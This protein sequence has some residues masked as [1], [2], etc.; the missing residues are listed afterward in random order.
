MM[1]WTRERLGD[2]LLKSGLVSEEQLEHALAVQAKQGGRLGRILANQSVITEEQL[3]QMIAEQ[4]HLELIDLA[5]YEVDGSVAR[6]VTAQAA[7]RHQ[8]LP[9]RVENDR[10]VVAMANP[11]DIEAIDT[12]RVMTGYDVQ[13]VV[14]TEGDISRGIRRYLESEQSVIMAAAQAT[15]AQVKAGPVEEAIEMENV[16]VVNL[17]NKLIDDAIEERAS[18]V[19]FEPQSDHVRV[20]YRIDGVLHDAARVPKTVEPSLIS[21]LKIMAEA[22]IS[23]KRVPQDGHFYFRHNGREVDVRAAVLPT[24]NGENVSLRLLSRG[25]S[26]MSLTQVGFEENVLHRFGDL[27]RKP[28]GAILVTGPTGSGKTTTMYAAI[29][30]LNDSEKKI[31]TIEDPV[32]YHIPGVMQTQVNIKTGLTFAVGLRSIVRCDPDI[33]LIG[34]IRDLETARIAVRSALTGHLVFSSLHAN[35][36]PSAM[37]TLI[38]MGV[39]PFVISSAVAGVLAQ[40]L[41]RRLCPRCRERYEPDPAFLEHIGMRIK[42][43][44]EPTFYKAVGCKH[45]VNTGY[46]GRTGVFE[47]MPITEGVAKLCVVDGSTEAIREAAVAEGM[48]L[49]RDDGFAKAK[50]GITTIEEI[51]RVVA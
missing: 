18:D 17:V 26:L 51:L 9:V 13:A 49:M 8:I 47:L 44:E 25:Q 4:K 20:R 21:R 32:E 28:Y 19:H 15:A 3:A 46:T 33:V 38:D 7:R 31:V 34:E 11:L 12:L 5:S 1:E 43:A 6:L 27:L 40:R 36:A 23:E 14:A 50:K 2:L 39:Q 29:N 30:E 24:V 22:D 42:E 35:D 41:A 48:I 37:T 45:C 10:L 16:P